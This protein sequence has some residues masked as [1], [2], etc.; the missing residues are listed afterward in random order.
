MRKQS[1]VTARDFNPSKN[2]TVD[3]IKSRV[4]DLADYIKENV[5]D[6]RRRDTALTHLETASMFA[7]KANFYEDEPETPQP[8]SDPRYDRIRMLEISGG[9]ISAAQ[10]FLDWVDEK[11]DAVCPEDD[12]GTNEQ[13]QVPLNTNKA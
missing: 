5:P 4:E 1:S 12:V 10:K 2:E 13:E 6:G 11:I 3:G 7:V 9:N 8:Y